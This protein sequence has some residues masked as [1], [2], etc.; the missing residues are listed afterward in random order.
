MKGYVL[1]IYP[2]RPGFADFEFKPL[3]TPLLRAKGRVPMPKNEAVTVD[4]APG[5]VHKSTVKPVK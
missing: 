3:S 5:S 4:I 2:T 1:G